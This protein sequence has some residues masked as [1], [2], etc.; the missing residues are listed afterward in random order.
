VFRGCPWDREVDA[1]PVRTRAGAGEL[2]NSRRSGGSAAVSEQGGA[3]KRV[4]PV[5]VSQRVKR[6]RR[7]RSAREDTAGQ[8]GPD[9]S[10]PPVAQCLFPF[11][12]LF[13]HA[14]SLILCKNLCVDPKIR[15][16]FG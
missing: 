9:P 6:G 3:D 1:V 7:A 5:S 14:E 8:L 2:H 4:P 13:K 16:I 12:L 11:S 10:G 15:A